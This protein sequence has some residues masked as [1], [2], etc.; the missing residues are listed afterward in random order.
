M[1]Q[2]CDE[3]T[4]KE[5]VVRTRKHINRIHNW[6]RPCMCGSGRCRPLTS[7]STKTC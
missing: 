6:R 2:H 1:R 5:G 3:Q 7:Q 4:A